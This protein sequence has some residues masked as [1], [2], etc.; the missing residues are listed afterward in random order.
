MSFETPLPPTLSLCFPALNFYTC[1]NQEEVRTSGQTAPPL[2]PPLGPANGSL[3][4]LRS[5]ESFLERP[6]AV[7]FVKTQGD[8]DAHFSV[9]FRRR[10][11]FT[12]LVSRVKM[13]QKN[14]SCE[15]AF[16]QHTMVALYLSLPEKSWIVFCFPIVPSTF[17]YSPD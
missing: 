16:K 15:R 3:I 14:A 4:L 1:T 8:A 7:F 5:R 2:N 17:E 10:I 6:L 13:R 11:H 9:L 12:K